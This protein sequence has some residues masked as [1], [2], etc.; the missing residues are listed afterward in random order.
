MTQPTNPT[1]ASFIR[2]I[3]NLADDQYLT[4]YRGWGRSKIPHPNE[5]LYIKSGVPD[6]YSPEDKSNIARIIL[7]AIGDLP[8]L[9]GLTIEDMTTFQKKIN[10][11]ELALNKELNDKTTTIWNTV[12]FSPSSLV[13]SSNLT[14]A[15]AKIIAL[16]NADLRLNF[17]NCINFIHANLDNFT[18]AHTPLL[19]TLLERSRI[20]SI[21]NQLQ[22]LLDQVLKKSPL[23]AE[24]SKHKSD[25]P[26][27]PPQDSLSL[28]KLKTMS[29]YDIFDIISTPG[30]LDQELSER[31]RRAILEHK[32]LS[33]DCKEFLLDT[34]LDQPSS[35]SP[36]SSSS[37]KSSSAKSSSS[38]PSPSEKPSSKEQIL[39]IQDASI[40]S[41]RLRELFTQMDYQTF[42]TAIQDNTYF[43]IQEEILP[44]VEDNRQLNPK[45]KLTLRTEIQQ[46]LPSQDKI[47]EL[48]RSFANTRIP[49]KPIT[50]VSLYQITTRNSQTICSKLQQLKEG[51]VYEISATDI[52]TQKSKTFQI[53]LPPIEEIQVIRGD[54]NCYYRSLMTGLLRQYTSLPHPE[55]AA[56]FTSLRLKLEPLLQDM[57][58]DLATA[59]QKEDLREEQKIQPLYDSSCLF[60]DKLEE[61]SL[62]DSWTTPEQVIEWINANSK[63]DLGMVALARYALASSL[64]EH[65]DTVINELPL[66]IAIGADDISTYCNSAIKTMGVDAEGASMELGLLPQYLGCN[67]I[68]CHVDG[69]AEVPLLLH[70]TPEIENAIILH[71]PV[72]HYNLFLSSG[73]PVILG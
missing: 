42:L 46:L 30:S 13:A 36:Y 59:R 3:N 21:N 70:A 51:G 63:H 57:Q 18:E 67:A 37:A 29:Y 71:F 14:A 5:S 60:I 52:T 12:I 55:R 45:E 69:R 61:V 2:S 16:D 19:E 28:E 20:F 22:I 38:Q 34:L 39:D 65:Q 43:L 53:R 8:D 17:D 54:G 49:I 9:E 32:S 48:T 25:S 47:A 72:G 50:P 68:I 23:Y 26:P 6:H 33:L 66:S 35:S 24:A 15:L 4:T 73:Q 31:L 1:L 64:M 58:R 62:R 10:R 7:R 44:W 41:I 27:S 40:R 56:A 11:M